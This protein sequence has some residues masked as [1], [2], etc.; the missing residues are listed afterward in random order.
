MRDHTHEPDE[1]NREPIDE[2][3][4][5]EALFCRL[6]ALGRKCALPHF[7]AREREDEVRDDISHDAAVQVRCRELGC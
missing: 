4:E 6:L 7:R 3:S 5:E 1:G 2:R